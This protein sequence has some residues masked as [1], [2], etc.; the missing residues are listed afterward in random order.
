[1]AIPG[2]VPTDPRPYR[3]CHERTSHTD[4]GDGRDGGAGANR[5]HVEP[6]GAWRLRPLRARARV[7]VR[8]RA[9]RGVRHRPGAARARRGDRHRQRRAARRRGGRRGRCVRPGWREPRGRRAQRA[10]AR[11]GTQD[12]MGPRR[13]AGA[14]LRR[15]RVRRSGL[16]GRRDLRPR[17]PGGR[18]RVAPRLPAGRDDRHDQPHARGCR[19]RLLRRARAARTSATAGRTAAGPVGQRGARARPLRRPGRL[20]RDDA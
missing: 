10:R 4:A 20:A 15:R 19:R 12:P 6:V 11:A 16:I 5:R 1:M 18:R 13:R 7:G 8:A 17:P 14:P 3:R 2:E 9:G